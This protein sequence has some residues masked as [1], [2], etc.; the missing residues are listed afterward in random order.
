MCLTDLVGFLHII[1]G[2][3]SWARQFRFKEDNPLLVVL[4]KE[5]KCPQN[6][7]CHTGGETNV[8]CVACPDG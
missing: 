6:H 5:S 2:K 7:Y 3:A 8:A 4:L 1:V